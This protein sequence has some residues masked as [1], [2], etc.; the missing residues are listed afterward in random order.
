MWMKLMIS[1]ACYV[2]GDVMSRTC[3]CWGD[4]CGYA[5]YNRL[6]LWSVHL[7]TQGKIW[8]QVHEAHRSHT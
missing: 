5:W 8:K 6:M 7:D 4:G 2:M 3:M 1:Y